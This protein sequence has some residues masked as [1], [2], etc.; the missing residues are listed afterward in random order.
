VTI[1]DLI[2]PDIIKPPDGTAAAAPPE[3]SPDKVTATS[4]IKQMSKR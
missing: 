3:G 4:R 2:K 1:E